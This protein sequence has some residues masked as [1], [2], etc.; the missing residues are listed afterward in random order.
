MAMRGSRLWLLAGTGEGPELARLWLK[1]GWRL[2]VSVVTQEAA[3][4][5]PLHPDLEL[6]VGPLNGALALSAQ[7][8][9]AQ[10]EGD[11][12]QWLIDASHPFARQITATALAATRHRP[13]PLVRLERPELSASC[14][15]PLQQ[16]ED[17]P[18]H[19]LPDGDH[20]LLA[21]GARHLRQAAQQCQGAILHARVLPHPQ[22]LRQAQ[23]AGLAP[24]RIACFRPSANGAVEQALCHHWQITTILC[25]QSGGLTEALWLRIATA[26]KL[27]LLLLQRPT[28]P[29]GMLRLPFSSLVDHVGRPARKESIE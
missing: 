12:F 16:L 2:R 15:T 5:Y 7:L 28:E 27:R 24:N 20:L 4:A 18:T 8:E 26:L 13:E 29:E 22:A 1:Q 21:I 10:L 14:A 3:K 6:V 17:L 19:L 9:Q 11:P 25:R 23:Q